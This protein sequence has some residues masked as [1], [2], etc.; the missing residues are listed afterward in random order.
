[1][2]VDHIIFTSAAD[3]A[4]PLWL[5]SLVLLLGLITASGLPL[6]R[7]VETPGATLVIASIAGFTALVIVAALPVPFSRLT[8]GAILVVATLANLVLPRPPLSIPPL[9]LTFP[10]AAAD[11][12]HGIEFRE[13]PVGDFDAMTI[14]VNADGKTLRAPS[15]EFFHDGRY[16]IP[17]ETR[18]AFT[19]SFTAADQITGRVE[20]APSFAMFDLTLLQ[21]EHP[22]D[23]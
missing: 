9:T 12:V 8:V 23:Q 1:M 21:Y 13:H 10:N 14:A 22:D 17:L 6:V 19:L 15:T 7:R 20:R 4:N 5:A 18:G 11:Y 2:S 3:V 16:V